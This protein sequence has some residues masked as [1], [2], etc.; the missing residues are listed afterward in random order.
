V[1]HYGTIASGNQ[2]IKHGRSRDAIASKLNSKPDSTMCFELEAAGVFRSL[3]CIVIR[4]ISDYCDSH[5]NDAWQ[6]YAAA[7]A[8]SL[9]PLST[10]VSSKRY[11]GVIHA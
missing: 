9:S 11:L 1:I 6:E 2:V 5:K 4:G 3:P 8:A 10:K 7:T